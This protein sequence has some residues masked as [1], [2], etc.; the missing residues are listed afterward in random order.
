[1]TRE[2][3]AMSETSYRGERLGQ[4][5]G[6]GDSMALI[7]AL[8]NLSIGKPYNQ[9]STTRCSGPVGFTTE[10]RNDSSL[11]IPNQ[12]PKSKH[13]QQSGVT[14]VI[15]PLYCPVQF[16]VN[17]RIGDRSCIQITLP[18]VRV[19]RRRNSCGHLSRSYRRRV[20]RITI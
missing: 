19:S 14:Y 20:L 6:R 1:M 2:F 3:G 9:M 7:H 4:S 13:T 16:V 12:V 8:S 15:H 18:P 10:N 17:R 5:E 11:V